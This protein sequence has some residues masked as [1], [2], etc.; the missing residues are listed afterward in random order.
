MTADELK[1][2]IDSKQSD[3]CIK[4][5]EIAARKRQIDD[6]N[7]VIDE[8][9]FNYICEYYTGKKMKSIIDGSVHTIYRIIK[10]KREDWHGADVT[11]ESYITESDGTKSFYHQCE[12]F[13]VYGNMVENRYKIII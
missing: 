6:I 2:L 4:Q 1:A 12:Y 11:F 10:I 3:I 9:L 13:D 5:D 7:A 8:T